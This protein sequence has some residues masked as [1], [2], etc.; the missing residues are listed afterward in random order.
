MRDDDIEHW[1]S[2]EEE[3]LPSSGFTTSV[4]EAVRREAL[5]PP[6]IPFPWK[7]ALPGIIISGI[8]LLWVLFA[9]VMQTM[10]THSEQ[11]P[12]TLFHF[13]IASV[14]A[15]PKAAAACWI[16]LALVLSLASLKLSTLLT[17]RSAG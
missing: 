13:S 7:Q 16:A 6:P 8:T 10:Q 9:G 17:Q 14:L 12:P 4:M 3:I 5:T 11:S 1:L 15:S 2:R